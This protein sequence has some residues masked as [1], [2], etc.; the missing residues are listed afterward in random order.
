MLNEGLEGK[1]ICLTGGTG[2]LGGHIL[3]LLSGY[4]C[5]ITCLVRNP[6]KKLPDSVRIVKGDLESGAG[7]REALENQ[8]IVIHAAAL[9]FGTG[10]QDYL[11]AN[12]K[13]CDNLAVHTGNRKVIYISSLA[14]AGPCGKSPG[15]K[16]TDPVSPVSAYGWSK[17]ACERTLQAACGN[18]LIFRPPIIYGSGDLGLLP[19][20]KSVARGFAPSPGFG[21]NFPVSIIHA[22]DMARAIA[23]GI[24]QDS[25]GIFHLNDGTEQDMDTLCAA[26]G[27]AIGRNPKVLHM[28]LSIMAISA[29]LSTLFGRAMSFAGKSRPP[30]WN[31]DKYREA[32]QEGWL[33]NADKVEREL[34]FK[35]E[36]TLEAGMEESVQG[37]RKE[38]LL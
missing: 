8:D 18:L 33:A 30:R 12:V 1:R 2:F 26:M 11:A 23:F 29:R 37:Y 16:E 36:V 24:A 32:A 28:P 5:K 31:F 4:G 27:K 35:P 7:I 34:G 10:W 19:L 21:R 9:L 20:F 15:K 3:K 22:D 14:A 38:G 6:G 17:L 25:R 13:A